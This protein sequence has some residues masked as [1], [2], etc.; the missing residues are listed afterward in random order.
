MLHKIYETY[1]TGYT[2]SDLN[3]C[4]STHSMSN[5]PTECRFV[6]ELFQVADLQREIPFYIK[7]HY[8]CYIKSMKR[9]T[10]D[11]RIRT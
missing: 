4:K 6:N 11:T 8:R 7:S 2:P 3:S 1:D 10:R 5:T 9:M